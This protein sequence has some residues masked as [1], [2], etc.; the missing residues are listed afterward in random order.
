M[1]PEDAKRNKEIGK[2]I[3]T[4]RESKNIQSGVLAQQINASPSLIT[5]IEN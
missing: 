1:N 4:I 5:R 2:R 3:K